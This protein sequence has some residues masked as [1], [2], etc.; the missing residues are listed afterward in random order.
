MIILNDKCEK[1]HGICKFHKKPINWTSGNSDVNR[2]I[3]DTQL[4][5]Y[6]D[7][8]E[9]LEWIPYDRFCDIKYIAKGGYGKV[10]KA[11]WIDGKYQNMIVALKSL[12]NSKKIT[13]EFMNEVL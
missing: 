8:G 10:Y 9:A 3:Q 7:A 5:A 1:C 4:L 11:V 12:N 6:H 2:F 13:L